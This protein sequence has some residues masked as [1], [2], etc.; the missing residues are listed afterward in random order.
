MAG[1]RGGW[2]RGAW[3]QD[4]EEAGTEALDG[5]IQRRL[6]QR[7]LVARYRGGWDRGA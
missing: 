7:R 4:T 3:W 2:D 1:Y 6:G 5:R